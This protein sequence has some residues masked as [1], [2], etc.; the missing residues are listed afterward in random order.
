MGGNDTEISDF[1]TDLLLE[2]AWWDPVTIYRTGRALGLAS[3]ASYRFERG[4]DVEGCAVALERAAALVAELAGGEVRRGVVDAYPT[5]HRASSVPLR[6]DRLNRLLGLEVEPDRAAAILEA[7]EFQVSRR[8]GGPWTVQVPSHR[9][10]ISREEDLIEEVG[11]IIGYDQVPETM[12]RVQ[13][14]ERGRLPGADLQRSVAQLLEAA[15]FYQAVN[16]SFVNRAD[17]ARFSTWPEEVVPL[18]NPMSGSGEVMRSSLLPHLVRNVKHNIHYGTTRVRLYEIG[19][20]FRQQPGDELPGEILHL[21]M[22]ATGP[23]RPPHWSDTEPDRS[24]VFDLTGP[25]EG[26]LRRL[27][28][29]APEARPCQWPAFQDGSGVSWWLHGVE[30]ARFGT[31]SAAVADALDLEQPVQLGEVVL[32]ELLADSP[33]PLRIRPL[34]RFPSVVR[35]LSLVLPVEHA[36]A[37]VV[38]AIR[39]VD[40]ETVVA[41]TPFDRYTG[42]G[43]PAGTVG[44]SISILFQ[45]ASRTLVSEEV[46][47][48]QERIVAALDE[49]LGATLRSQEKR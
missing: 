41:V 42:K 31:L 44:L 27:R 35:D 9:A 21:G 11:R 36:Y 17:D 10:D 22:V 23:S 47:A 3:D 32:E 18:A 26:A 7:L 15:G 25:M 45:H 8:G 1:T 24:D 12:P 29:P 39:S 28:R 48:I 34:P 43:L 40:R 13:S 33:E 20:A 19:R 46:D 14:R 6:T 37:D 4:A 30:V 49:K 16:F 2:A 5:P 38:A